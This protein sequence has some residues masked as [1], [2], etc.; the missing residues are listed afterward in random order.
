MMVAWLA[1]CTAMG[2]QA[3]VRNRSLLL[4]LILTWLVD[5]S[6]TRLSPWPQ[7]DLDGDG[8][9]DLVAADVGTGFVSVLIGNGNGT[10]K[11]ESKFAVGTGPRSVAVGDVNGDG[12]LDIV[13]GNGN[14]NNVTVLLGNQLGGSM[15]AKG[16]G[17]FSLGGNYAVD[18]G[19]VAVAIVDMNEDGNRTW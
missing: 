11:S 10:L 19:P 14:S 1:S 2:L 3:Q 7:E 6:K 9:L 8:K 15:P 12:I 4:L 17:T 5:R 13:T 16:D 18:A